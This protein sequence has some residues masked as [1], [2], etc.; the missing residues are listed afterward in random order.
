[1]E[2]ITSRTNPLMAHLRKLGS[3]HSY[4]AKTGEY[5]GDGGKLL[6]EALRWGAELKTVVCTPD[7]ALP[8]LP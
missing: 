5:L 2:H 4:R 6:E 3:S 8:A 1:M 7:F